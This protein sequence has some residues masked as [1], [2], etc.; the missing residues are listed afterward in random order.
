MWPLCYNLMGADTITA[1]DFVRKF[2]KTCN[3]SGKPNYQ[4][5]IIKENG[6]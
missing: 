3:W 2:C 6:I 1:T 5:S 4:R